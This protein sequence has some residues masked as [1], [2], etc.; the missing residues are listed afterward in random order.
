[1]DYQKNEF[2]T[3]EFQTVLSRQ[4]AYNPVRQ[5]GGPG[6]GIQESVE[7]KLYEVRRMEV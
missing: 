2:W 4:D 5:I 1:M 7:R 3:S 6:Q